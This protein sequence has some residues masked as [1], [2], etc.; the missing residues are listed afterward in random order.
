AQQKAVGA[1]RIL[2]EAQPELYE[3]KQARELL[4]L[5]KDLARDGL[6]EEVFEASQESG[7]RYRHVFRIMYAAEIQAPLNPLESEDTCDDSTLTQLVSDV[8]SN[9]TKSGWTAGGHGLVRRALATPSQ[10]LLFIL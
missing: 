8:N 2:N 1:S 10:S 5:L 3:R 4:E 6:I 7:M 9:T